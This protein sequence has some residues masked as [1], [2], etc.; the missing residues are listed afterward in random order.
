MYLSDDSGLGAAR[1]WA[2]RRRPASGSGR[3]P[4]RIA[5]LGAFGAS[6]FKVECPD[7]PGCAPVDAAGCRAAIRAAVRE[8][9]RLANIA[10]TR[11]AA[12][13]H[14]QRRARRHWPRSDRGA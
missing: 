11:I 13:P 8:A 5:G 9:I 2:H 10:A 14:S 1:K 3:A 7:P 12:R 4:S 6:V